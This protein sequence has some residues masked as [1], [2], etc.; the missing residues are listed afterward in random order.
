MDFLILGPLEA[1]EGDEQLPLGGAKQ[2]GLLALLLIR[3]NEVVSRDRLIDELWGEDPPKAA[4]N[5]LQTYVSHLRK[6]IGAETLV[7]RAPGYA[8][9]IAPGQLD[10]HNFERLVEEAGRALGDGD[11]KS[12]AGSCR[13]ALGLWRGPALADFT[14][15]PFAEP[16]IARLEELRLVALERR[17]D[18]DIELGRH[19][20]LVGELEGLA[21]E[22]PLRERLR[23]QLM[24]ALYRSGRQ[25]EALE[26]YQAARRALVDQLGIEPTQSLQEL[27]TAILQQDPSL[28]LGPKEPRETAETAALPPAEE[29]PTP[30]R[31]ILVAPQQGSHFEALI[32]LAEPL[33]RQPPREI[34][35][36]HLVV[37]GEELA[38]AT[39]FLRDRRSELLARRISARVA[40]F[41]S[42]EP[43]ED[44]VRLAS[45]QDVD[46]LLIAV[47]VDDVGEGKPAGDLAL[48]LEGAPCDVGVLVVREEPRLPG[49]ELP[50]LVPF[51]GY[52]NDWA[53]VEIGAWIASTQGSSLRLLGS[54]GEP[55]K[56]QRDASRLLASVSLM[57]QQVSGVVADPLLVPP[58][59][60]AVIEAAA[61]SGLVVVGLSEEWQKT[62]IGA[63]RAFVAKDAVPQVVLV[64]GGLRPGGLAPEQSLTRFTWTMAGSAR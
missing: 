9:E 45:Q 63:D 40:A 10:L 20:E 16:V 48:V 61:E 19:E 35:L 6:V 31:S 33:S 43:G 25:A 50:V 23:A 1:R 39:A 38:E 37:G 57:V 2:R 32:G 7:T 26:G 59:N 21:A 12:A 34:I 5:V 22:H 53:A 3:A 44:M 17:I 46:L 36:A 47:A 14:Y 29:I 56:G 54:S 42:S 52:D 13:E 41:T 49:P 8:I 18:A 28:E 4:A 30:D 58:G 51:A 11:A 60:E 62:G 64:R 55:K 24:L 15:E 27:N